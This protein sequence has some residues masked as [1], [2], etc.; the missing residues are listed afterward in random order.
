MSTYLVHYGIKGMKWGVRRYQ[1]ADG[2]YTDAGRRRHR[3]SDN[4]TEADARRDSKIYG[5]RGARRIGR[6]IERGY[7]LEGA[8]ARE[9]RRPKFRKSYSAMT[10]KELQRSVNRLNQEAQYKTM[11]KSTGR[12]FA[13]KLFAVTFTAAVVGAATKIGKKYSDQIFTSVSEKLPS[14]NEIVTY[15]PNKWNDLHNL[16]GSMDDYGWG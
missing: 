4:Y 3:I 13:E 7:S 1:N 12:K 9:D 16:Y 15:L 14:L 6:R 8:R 2:S 5:D 10:D 11:T